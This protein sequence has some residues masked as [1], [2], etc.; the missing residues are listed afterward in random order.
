VRGGLPSAIAALVL[1]TG[2]LPAAAEPDELSARGAVLWD[3]LDDVVLYAH[4]ERVPRPPASTTKVMTV[5]LALE[6][7]TVDDIVTVS[8]QA[9]GMGGASLDLFAGQRIPMRSLL[10]GLV[11][12]SGNDA[13]VAVAEHV[14]GSEDAFVERMNARATE[15]GLLDTRFINATGL[16]DDLAHQSSPL[17]LARLAAV[18][19]E[20]PDFADW[21]AAAQMTVPGLPSM[22]SRNELL[23]R[24]PGADGV[25][26]GFTTLA[27][28]TLVASATRGGW[29]LYAVVLGSEDSFADAAALLD[30]GFTGWRR[31]QPVQ[32]DTAVTHYRWADADT[33]VMAGEALAATIPVDAAVT[34]RTSLRPGLGRPVTAGAAVGEAQLLID[35]QVDRTVTLTAA[36][37]VPASVPRSAAGGV[38]GAVQEALRAFV[39]S[40][41]LE[42]D[43]EP[44]PAASPAD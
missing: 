8:A 44:P 4:D 5:L 22:V 11:L 14:A 27:G 31:V 2:A 29:R 41:P 38:G 42:R 1:L 33:A 37:D 30:H 16:T 3:A 6:A 35:G 19:M 36:D 34:W 24:Y 23:G 10:A 39:L 25:K 28:F 7:G 40:I 32:P 18:A 21:A 15:L 17:D 43:V 26:T 9:A 12:R 20:H 13:A